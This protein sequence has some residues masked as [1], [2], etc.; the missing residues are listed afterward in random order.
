[1]AEPLELDGVTW[2]GEAVDDPEILEE[3]PEVLRDILSVINGFVLFGGALHVRGAV[4][5]PSWHSLRSVWKGQ[6]AL[7]LLYPGVAP[8]DVPF[9]QDCVGDQLLLR[10]TAVVSLSAETGQIAPLAADLPD[11]LR[12]RNGLNR[13]C[14]LLHRHVR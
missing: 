6:S 13:R 7:C 9:A 4:R 3:V 2:T 5:M 10:G 1:M 8:D 12:S 14:G 11:Y